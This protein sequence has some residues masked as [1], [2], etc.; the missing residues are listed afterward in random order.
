MATLSSCGGASETIWRP[1]VNDLALVPELGILAALDATLATAAYQLLSGHPKLGLDALARGHL[2]S[3]EA[4]HA[5]L[6]L[7]RIAELRAT[8]RD[9]RDIALGSAPD[10]EP[11]F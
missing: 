6:L 9:Y 11:Q 2:P 5:S 1:S 10:D 3:E 7:F 4:R 8:V